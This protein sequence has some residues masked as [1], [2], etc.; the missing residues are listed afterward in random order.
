[1]NRNSLTLYM[2]SFTMKST[3]YIILRGVLEVMKCEKIM[4][5][6]LATV[7]C[8]SCLSLPSFAVEMD[9]VDSNRLPDYP[10]GPA[11]E[12]HHVQEVGL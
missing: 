3:P 5:A 4:G 8:L 9:L 10:E 7:L 6:A 2:V 1:M 11:P 12:M